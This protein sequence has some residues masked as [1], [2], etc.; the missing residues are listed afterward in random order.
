MT[1]KFLPLMAGVLAALLSLLLILWVLDRPR[2][3]VGP[4]PSMA[5]SIEAAARE[6][7]ITHRGRVLPMQ[8]ELD[9]IRKRRKRLDEVLRDLEDGIARLILG[10]LC[11]GLMASPFDA[12]AADVPPPAPAVLT[13][14]AG[15]LSADGRQCFSVTESAMIRGVFAQVPP[16]KLEVATLYE[17][18]AL[19]AQE[20]GL[21]ESM[22]HETQRAYDAERRRADAWS[23]LEAALRDQ[24]KQLE[25]VI[26]QKRRRDHWRRAG[27][28][29]AVVAGGAVVGYAVAR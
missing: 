23:G 8:R 21:L 5:T 24:V 7:A 3:I 9:Q 20:I 25:D 17:D 12:F 27:I 19:A 28:I 15:K 22:L 14:P 18:R 4:S 1:T 26:A 2:A 29:A 6:D 10:F 11:V 13:M 16:L